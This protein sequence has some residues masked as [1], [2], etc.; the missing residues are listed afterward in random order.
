MHDAKLLDACRER[1]WPY[2][3][4]EDGRVTLINADCLDVLPL[5]E[6]GSVDCVVTSPPYNMI[7][8]SAP[9]GIYAEHSRK[10]NDGY[11]SHADD[12]PQDEYEDWVRSVAAEC[13]RACNGIVWI[14]HKCKFVNREARHP[15]RIFPWPIHTEIIWDRG[16]SLTLNARR[17]APS[18]EVVLGFGNS[19]YWDRS[20]DTLLTV[21]RINPEKNIDGHPCPFPVEIPRRLIRASCTPDGTAMDPFL[22]SGTTGVAA[23]RLG[24]RFIGIELEPRYFQ[25]AIDR[26]KAE[27]NRMALFE[28]PP[29]VLQ[30][31]SLLET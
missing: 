30:Q 13:V 16:G 12:M 24:R 14:N 21:W 25:I 9:S 15:A 2:W 5:I 17:F 19:A 1:G 28:P 3:A 7:P 4:T 20:T 27:L 10:L 8:K 23:V 22:G 26:I 18:H 11:V 6:R 29:K 31:K